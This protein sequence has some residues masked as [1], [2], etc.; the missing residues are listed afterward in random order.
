M[1]RTVTTQAGWQRVDP[2]HEAAPGTYRLSRAAAIARGNATTGAVEMRCFWFF[3]GSGPAHF[4]GADRWPGLE[5]RMP[6]PEGHERRRDAF[7]RDLQEFVDR[8]LEEH[9]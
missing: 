4:G 6:F 8:W 2:A 9:P 3:N 1:K 5:L 7:A